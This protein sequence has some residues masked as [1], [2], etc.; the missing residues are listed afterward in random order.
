MNDDFVEVTSKLAAGDQVILAPEA[1][2]KSGDKVQA[3]IREPAAA[4][5]PPTGD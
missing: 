3:N 4:S 1:N 2:L 5:L